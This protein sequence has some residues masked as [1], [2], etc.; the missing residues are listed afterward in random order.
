MVAPASVTAIKMN[1]LDKINEKIILAILFVATPLIALAII[2]SGA[3]YVLN[4]F[5]K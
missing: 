5:T 4:L 3:Y 2:A 1:F